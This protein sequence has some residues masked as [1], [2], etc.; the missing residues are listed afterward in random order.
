MGVAAW[1]WSTRAGV[2]LAGH[3][4]H[5]ITLGV[6]A[7]IAAVLLML[8]VRDLSS[9]RP[10]RS[11]TWVVVTLNAFALLFTVVVLGSMI[12][13]RPFSAA[14]EAIDALRGSPEVSATDATT[15][16][17][18]TP[19]ASE[20]HTGLIFQPGARV[21]PR[22]YVPL[23]SDLAE[24]GYL[25]VIVKQPFFIGFT[26]LGAPGGVIEAHPEI[27]DWVVGGHSLGGVAASSYAGDHPDQIG[28]LLLWASYPSGS[29]ADSNL[30]VTSVSGTED[31]LAGPAD[32]EAAR[33]ELPAD[34]TF[35][36]VQGAV[37]AFFGDYGEQ[38][39]DGMPTVPRAE[40]QQQ[41][42]DASA[43]LLS[44]ASSR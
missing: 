6:I 17:T 32:I 43:G 38:P 41:I 31:G 30:A 42:L 4:A 3:P 13:L 24:Q 18:L 11:R 7:V 2:L 28:G 15:T 44:A 35:V 26:A 25:V 9:S 22:A 39:G 5:M 33:N 40:A 37:H 23:M 36:A 1:S 16:I 34:A 12:Y 21:D 10:L 14:A 19:V 27:D 20:P 29:L 8:G